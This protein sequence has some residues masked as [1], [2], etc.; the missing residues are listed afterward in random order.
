MSGRVL[1]GYAAVLA[2][3]ALLALALRLRGPGSAPPAEEPGASDATA[4]GTRGV[5]PEAASGPGSRRVSEVPVGPVSRAHGDGC[6]QVVEFAVH[7]ALKALVRAQ[8]PDGSWG[9]GAEAFEGRIHTPASATALAVLA[10]LGAG[11]THL[12]KDMAA[13]GVTF[14]ASMKQALKWLMAC[15]P[16]DAFE[17]GIV[18]LALSEYYGLTASALIRNPAEAGLHRLESWQAYEAAHGDR[19]GEAWTAMAATSARLS[20]LEFDPEATARAKERV[21]ARLEGGPDPLAAASWLL[22][23]NDRTHAGLP[24]VRDAL[25]AALPEP[26]SYSYADGYFATLA[27]FQIDGPGRKEGK[28]EAWKAW[29]GAIR[30]VLVGKQDRDG[31]WPGVSG[32]TGDALRNALATMTLEIYYRYASASG[33]R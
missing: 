17:S 5:A 25:A 28:G 2:L 31:T 33:A 26:A 6:G 24:A 7:R 29:E 20:G 14:G 11:Y 3:A 19:L 21:S 27:L 10:L 22:L 1:K 18:A 13:D 8:N 9:D 23:T 12:S 15:E 16:A 32:R 4:G 30:E